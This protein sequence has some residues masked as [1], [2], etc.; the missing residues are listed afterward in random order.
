MK[1]SI[2]R[3]GVILCALIALG[4]PLAA[5]AGMQLKPDAPVP[6]PPAALAPPA[7]AVA[8]GT[9]QAA[10]PGSPRRGDRTAWTPCIRLINAVALGA[11]IDDE[12]RQAISG[13]CA[14]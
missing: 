9:L 7:A 3:Q 8:P 6:A 14:N 10:K 13:K 1:I 4:P 5:Q 12:Q 11:A 2:Q